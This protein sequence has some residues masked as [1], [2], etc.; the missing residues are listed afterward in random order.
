M[1]HDPSDGLELQGLRVSWLTSS[2]R[3]E[4][5][6]PGALSVRDPDD[7]TAHFQDGLERLLDV[8][9]TCHRLERRQR[10]SS[11]GV[12]TPRVLGAR[13]RREGLGVV[14]HRHQEGRDRDRRGRGRRRGVVRR[15][16]DIAAVPGT[17]GQKSRFWLV[18]TTR[19]ETDFTRFVT[20]TF[21]SLNFCTSSL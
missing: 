12:V 10:C 2:S 4:R 7:V 18:G 17:R 11:G 1:C 6:R 9:A 15:A 19:N 8:H 13:G 21:F 5:R 3:E 16:V 20:L 14:L